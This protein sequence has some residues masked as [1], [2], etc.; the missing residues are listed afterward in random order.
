LV[1][2]DYMSG[3]E[4]ERETVTQHEHYRWCKRHSGHLHVNMFEALD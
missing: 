2:D 1:A 4:R 3:T